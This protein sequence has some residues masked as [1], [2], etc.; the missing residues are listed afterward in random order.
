MNNT[1]K[2]IILITIA[3]ISFLHAS[4]IRFNDNQ[5]P[6]EAAN[7][8]DQKAKVSEKKKYNKPK[9]MNKKN[10]FHNKERM[11]K[12]MILNSIKLRYAQKVNQIEQCVLMAESQDELKIC[13]QRVHNLSKNIHKI[14]NRMNKVHKKGKKKYKNKM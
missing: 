14:S 12:A 10:M 4:E 9:L 5:I 7:P 3:S 11:K 6:Q 13:N 1:K 2:I 8:V